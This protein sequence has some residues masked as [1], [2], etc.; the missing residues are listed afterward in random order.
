MNALLIGG[1]PLLSLLC[2]AQFRHCHRLLV[3]VLDLCARRLVRL[4]CCQFWEQAVRSLPITCHTSPSRITKCLRV[5]CR[6][7]VDDLW[8]AVVC[9][10]SPGCL[11]ERSGYLWPT[12]PRFCVYHALQ[13]ALESGQRL[14]MCKLILAQPLIGSTI[15]EFSTS[16]ALWVLEDLCCLYW[17][18]SYQID[19]SALWWTIVSLHRCISL[20]MYQE[21]ECHRAVF[22]ALYCS[23][24]HLGAFSILDNK[25]IGYADDFTLL[26]VVPSPSRCKSFSRRVPESWPRQG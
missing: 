5:W 26:S 9:S 22:W 1:G 19:H 25:L 8:N 16:S 23:P 14:G 4:I 21:Q 17:R 2:L 18:S 11:S 20:T 6:F 13:S 24:R 7:V 12:F 10:Q 15:R 3:G